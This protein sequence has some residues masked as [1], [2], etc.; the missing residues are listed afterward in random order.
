[1][2]LFP[3]IEKMFVAVVRQQFVLGS[4]YSIFLYRNSFGANQSLAFTRKSFRIARVSLCAVQ[5]VWQ[6]ANVLQ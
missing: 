1:M 3:K 2:D 6:P 4:N 5:Q